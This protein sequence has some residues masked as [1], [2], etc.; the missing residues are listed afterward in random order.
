MVV[1]TRFFIA[2][3][4][5][6]K[7]RYF[8]E[9]SVMCSLQVQNIRYGTNKYKGTFGTMYQIAKE[10]GIPKLWRYLYHC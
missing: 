7:I 8:H 9:C 10:E 3:L 2:P 6:V 5:V 4:D 1:V